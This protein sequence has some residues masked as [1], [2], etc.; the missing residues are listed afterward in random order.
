MT[1]PTFRQLLAAEKPLLLP[2]AH[3]ALSARMIEQAGYKAF[4]IG[5]FPLV[6]A[7]YA[8]PDVGIAGLEEIRS[9]IADIFAACDLPCLIDADDGYGDVKNV[10][11]T[12]RAYERLGASAFFIEDQVA[13]KR[14]GHMAGKDVV[15]SAVMEAKIAAAA[16]AR[17]N[18][19]MFLIAR[20]DARAVHGLD[21]ALR[22]GERYLKAGADGVF[23]EAPQSVEELKQIGRALDAVQMANM[24]EGGQTPILKPDTLYEMG[25][26]IVIFG[27]S[28][29]LRAAKTV[30]TA[31]AG[32]K[33]GMLTGEAVTADDFHR[34]VRLGDWAR[35]EDDFPIHPT[36][37]AA[38]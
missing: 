2:G 8:L 27:I 28:M 32:L 3:D 6:G 17:E 29:A 1:R 23:V 7:R 4:L 5:G 26:D 13:P 18:K 21:E 31:L 35:L 38:S 14:C 10:T 33:Q 9:G 11:N 16:A 24:L 20:T 22:R 12:V 30:E 15:P 19:E 34:I 25:Y 37:E 36:E